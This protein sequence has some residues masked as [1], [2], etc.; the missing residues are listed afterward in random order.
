MDFPITYEHHLALAGRPVPPDFP[1][2]EE[3][4]EQVSEQLSLEQTGQLK[5]I[6]NELFILRKKLGKHTSMSKKDYSIKE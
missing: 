3:P 4:K 6:H 1:P 5:Q 2:P